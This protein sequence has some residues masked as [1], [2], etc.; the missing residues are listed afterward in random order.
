MW[1][2]WT[3]AEVS[4]STFTLVVPGTGVAGARLVVDKFSFVQGVQCFS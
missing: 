2:Q 1:Y 4:R 3:Q